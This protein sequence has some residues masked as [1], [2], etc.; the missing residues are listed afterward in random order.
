M[1]VLTYFLFSADNVLL[2]G[3]KLMNTG[4][5]NN[6]RIFI[7]PTKCWMAPAFYVCRTKKS[8][9]VFLFIVK[10]TRLEKGILHK[11]NIYLAAIS[12]NSV[13]FPDPKNIFFFSIFCPMHPLN[14][15]FIFVTGEVYACCVYSGTQE[16]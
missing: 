5:K 3:S 6:C 2:A 13:K 14:H 15:C 4:T 11:K 9:V 8:F 7:E 10:E 1:Y 12:K 16:N